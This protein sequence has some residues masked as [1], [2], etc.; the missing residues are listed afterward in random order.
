MGERKIKNIE[1]SEKSRG[2]EN[3]PHCDDDELANGGRGVKHLNQ[4]LKPLSLM[5]LRFRLS[6]YLAAPALYL[7]DVRCHAN[8]DNLSVQHLHWVLS[9]LTRS[10]SIIS[11]GVISSQRWDDYWKYQ[12]AQVLAVVE[13]TSWRGLGEQAEDSCATTT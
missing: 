4:E 6:Y 8:Y 10:W 12:K 9:H 1:H 2:T 5:M 3:R 11:G 13:Y 7:R